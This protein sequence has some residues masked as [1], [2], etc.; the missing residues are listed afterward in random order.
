MLKYPL[1]SVV[2]PTLNQVAFISD[3]I[4]SVL[5]Q[6][7]P[8]I[9]LIV[10]D[11]GSTD[12]TVDLLK[13]LQASDSR[14][15]WFSQCDDGPAQAINSALAQ[16]RG[17][18]IG[19]LNSDDIYASGAIARAVDALQSNQTWLMA[20]GQGQHADSAGKP[21]NDYPTLP[22]TTPVAQ[23]A[24]GCFICQPTV[25]FRRSMFL[26]LGKLD[27]SLKTAFDFDYWLRAFLVFQERIG[28]VDAVQ[29]YSR[30]HEN[31]ITLRMRRTVAL[32]GMQVLARH[33]GY[34]PKEWLL[35]YVEELLAMDVADLG[36]ADL[37]RHVH[38][39]LDEAAPFLTNQAYLQAKQRINKD[40]RLDQLEFPAAS[41]V[42]APEWS[43]RTFLSA[44]SL[45]SFCHAAEAL[46]RTQLR[47]FAGPFDWLFSNLSM[48]T[49]CIEDDFKE[50]LDQSK[51]QVLPL[52]ARPISEANVCDHA[53]YRDQFGV[54]YLF[55]HHDPTQDDVYAHFQRTV[56]RFRKLPQQLSP[57]LFLMVTI[58]PVSVKDY[59]MLVGH[60]ER[61]M[62]DF[63]L[64]VVRFVSG[65]T[66]DSQGGVKL[67]QHHFNFVSVEFPVM[68]PSN[69]VQFPDEIDNLRFEAF[70]RTFKVLP[71]KFN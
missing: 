68:A 60:L 24:A 47:V 17:T 50:F 28:F 39:A 59:A 67:Y 69:G 62:G 49:H 29:A 51:Y 9:E 52:E 54:K 10:A 4:D 5:G 48:L 15:R 14:L 32:E 34:A 7:Y 65:Q 23:F 33:L 12:G 63:L 53:F 1:V 70:I 37:R 20:Y 64:V 3:A 46:K 31:C 2:M 71:G 40:T 45:G 27:E 19:W 56:E 41:N 26:L 8:Q 36:I 66:E 6:D 55:N 22:P 38:A 16:V 42:F 30:L 61:T 11:G 21:L 13:Q 57:I 43:E 35:T 18:I 25:F 44:I 58:Q